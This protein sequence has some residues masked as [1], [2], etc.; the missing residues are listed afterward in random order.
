MKSNVAYS[1]DSRQNCW[2]FWQHKINSLKFYER[3]PMVKQNNS[4]VTSGKLSAA[5]SRSVSLFISVSGRKSKWKNAASVANSVWKS[6][7][8]A[9]LLAINK[10]TIN[11]YMQ[12]SWSTKKHQSKLYFRWKLNRFY[13]VCR[14]IENGGAQ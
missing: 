4:N 7:A 8:T 14:L 13:K 3:K 5:L 11:K 6:I 9:I 10:A 12:K 1:G 2:L